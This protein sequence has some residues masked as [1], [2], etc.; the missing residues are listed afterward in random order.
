MKKRP[1]DNQRG[2]ALLLT[3]GILSLVLILA[4]SFAFTAR[5]N[6]QV[7]KVNADQVKARLL[8][9]SGWQRARAAMEWQFGITTYDNTTNTF[10][11]TGTYYYP[12]VDG[13]LGFSDAVKM[14]R[15]VY[16]Q[17]YIAMP[18][19]DDSAESFNRL[20]AILSQRSALVADLTPNLGTARFQTVLDDSGD[21]V[22]RLGFLVLEEGGKFDINQLVSPN[23]NP[24]GNIPFVQPGAGNLY[25]QLAKFDQTF[26]AANDFY[27]NILGNYSVASYAENATKR[28]GL[29]IQE[30][31][32][33]N[34]SF[35]TG[36]PQG[37]A[38]TRAE[39][40]SYDHLKRELGT[41]FTDK[42]LAY[43]F[44]SGKDIEAY[45]DVDPAAAYSS[46][47][48]RQRFDITGFEWRDAMLGSYYD[49]TNKPNP[50]SS[51]WQFRDATGGPSAGTP[52]ASAYA[53]ALV[54]ALINDVQR[55]AFWDGSTPPQ[56]AQVNRVEQATL[57]FPGGFG[58]PALR[59]MTGSYTTLNQ[60]VA[61]NLV[62]YSDSDSWA[63]VP[64]TV[65]WAAV[66]TTEID[67]CGNE[68]VPYFNE[69][70]C[71]IL[72]DKAMTETPP[73]G[74]G[75]YTYT[76][77][78]RLVPSVEMVNIFEENLTTGDCR[79]QIKGRWEFE[80]DGAPVASADFDIPFDFSG[81]T[82][83]AASYE[84]YPF[85][86]DITVNPSALLHQVVD[87]PIDYVNP[88]YKISIAAVY[89]VSGTSGDIDK[90]SDVALWNA[91]TPVVECVIPITSSGQQ[92]FYHNLE[93]KDP[94]C[95]HRSEHW[96]LNDTC[97]GGGCSMPAAGFHTTDHCFTLND[98]NNNFAPNHDGTTEDKELGVTFAG[99][100]KTFSTAF[101]RN[102]PMETLWE[103]GAI[104]R[105]EP[106]RTINLNKFSATV[107]GYAAGDA[108]ILDQV[109]IGPAK[110]CR[111]KFNP[112]AR[113]PQAIADLLS[114]IDATAYDNMT[115][116]GGPV[117]AGSIVFA[118]TPSQYRGQFV[119]SALSGLV[120]AAADDRTAE[121][122]IGKTAHLLS[123]RHDAYTVIIVAQAMRDLTSDGVSWTNGPESAT[124]DP[125]LKTLINPTEY[126]YTPIPPPALPSATRYCSILATQVMMA[127]VVRDAW[128]NEYEIVQFR[129]LED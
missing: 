99:T 71:R 20:G 1:D 72:V 46:S 129:Y 82:V 2:S 109:K 119:D 40:F 18:A 105:G 21:V 59:S 97:S 22:G 6:R 61:A 98:D 38:T 25:E 16:E 28:L 111:G 89:M 117:A 66:P 55:P 116:V 35:V 9:E 73:P 87:R 42:Y 70:A 76:Y 17:R 41:T 91:T 56:P 125:I 83:Q 127:H 3:L 88:Q 101:I 122:Y 47:V 19:T 115:T 92:I 102:A 37:F 120:T 13:R 39:W 43:R 7:A 33:I 64:S 27:Y 23:A 128:K 50:N 126:T 31:D 106:Y 74:S 63:T 113:N 94:R 49:S 84:V 8:A 95:N 80:A 86:E 44:F 60:Q 65:T 48:E 12:P 93:A 85:S 79:V 118:G 29:C 15:N 112:N 96:T 114:G 54:A 30:L 5:T 124:P 103:L 14:T 57:T 123:T 58:I 67:Y 51:G 77:R 108:L 10:A 45:W 100:K 107:G 62:D 53:R 69:V 75:V 34:N 110:F 36:R 121:A 68:K 90:I 26:N 32:V 4:M 11:K 104:H 24:N 52:G 78:L 81:L